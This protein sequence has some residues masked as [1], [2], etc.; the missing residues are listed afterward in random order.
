MERAIEGPQGDRVERDGAETTLAVRPGVMVSVRLKP[1]RSIPPNHLDRSK[2]T[3]FGVTC[4]DTQRSAWM[5]PVSYAWGPHK[6]YFQYA[7]AGDASDTV[8]FST[9]GKAWNVGYDYAFSKRTSAHVTTVH[10][11]DLTKVV[12]LR[13]KF[14]SRLR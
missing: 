10:K 9:G 14:A 6:V 3:N 1:L 13:A 11:V 5:L 8:G 4:G 7:R 12:K 2:L